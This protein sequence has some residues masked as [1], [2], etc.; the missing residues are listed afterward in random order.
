M[1]IDDN[2]SDSL[3][4]KKTLSEK[5]DELFQDFDHEINMDTDDKHNKGTYYKLL[6]IFKSLNKLENY[7]YYRKFKSFKCVL[8]LRKL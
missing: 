7:F 4:K 6:I 1:E 2:K 3:Q 8:L 5:N